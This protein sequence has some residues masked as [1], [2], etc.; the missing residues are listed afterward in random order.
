MRASLITDELVK[1]LKKAGCKELNF[2]FESGS[3][4]VLDLMNKQTKIEQMDNAI[5][6]LRKNK[7]GFFGTFIIGYP[8]EHKE[9]VDQTIA[10]C[11]RNGLLAKPFFATPYPGTP[12]YEQIKHQI[13]NMDKFLESLG[14]AR[15]LTINI[16]EFST[17]ELIAQRRRVASETEKAYL[18]KHP[19]LGLMFSPLKLLN[20]ETGFVV[21]MFID[22][23]ISQ[24]IKFASITG[25]NY[26]KGKKLVP[27]SDE[28]YDKTFQD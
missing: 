8:G 20:L 15:D 16:S 22:K 1:L 26:L 17:K 25:F 12:L 11:K 10:F 24:F 27:S 19:V 23:P 5:A 3:Q 18:K 21:K 9:D 4:R 7:M 14:D 28:G 2:G 13:K 6:V